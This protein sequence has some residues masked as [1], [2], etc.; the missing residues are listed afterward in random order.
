MTSKFL[1]G[2]IFATDRIEGHLARMPL[3]SLML[4]E[5]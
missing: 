1:P 3:E 4:I 2:V 5:F